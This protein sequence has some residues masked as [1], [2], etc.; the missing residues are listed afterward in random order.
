[1]GLPYEHPYF[2]N[3]FNTFF[4]RDLVTTPPPPPLRIPSTPPSK[5]SSYALFGEF[6]LSSSPILLTPTNAA[7]PTCEL[8]RR[9]PPP[10]T[11]SLLCLPSFLYDPFLHHF[12]ISL[13]S[14]MALSFSVSAA[15]PSPTAAPW[16]SSLCRFL[17]SSS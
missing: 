5:S 8:Q 1:M 2:Y 10:T 17:F 9:F 12:S 6:S 13:T 11:T 14:L 4:I 15:S 7:T 3:T 16:C